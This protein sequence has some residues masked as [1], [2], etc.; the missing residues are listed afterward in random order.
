[1]IDFAGL[2]PL[3]VDDDKEVLE[4]MYRDSLV[5]PS[6]YRPG[7]FWQFYE[8][9]HYAAL[10]EHSLRDLGTIGSAIAGGFNAEEDYPTFFDW[11][12][13]I[14]YVN[15]D[16]P[17]F[18]SLVD[19]LNNIVKSAPDDPFLPYSLSISSLR[20]AAT[21]YCEYYGATRNARPLSDVNWPLLGRPGDLFNYKGKAV[22]YRALYYYTKYAFAAKHVNFDEIDVIVEL[23][24][25][26]GR[27]AAMIIDLHPH[28]TYLM[29]D[30]PTTLYF[31][32]QFL[33]A[34][35]PDRVA[36]YRHTRE[37]S[38]LSGLERGKIY[39]FGSWQFPLLREFQAAL[40]WNCQSLQEMEAEMVANYTAIVD[41]FAKS[42]LLVHSIAGVHTG[43]AG[44][45]SLKAP[46]ARVAD[47]GAKYL[48]SFDV[49][50]SVQAY[51]V[52]GDDLGSG[53]V[54]DVFLEKRA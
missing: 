38:S 13:G 6:I 34:A 51:D 27:Q 25:G 8:D 22:T 3:I 12:G 40:F 44:T 42:V 5:G 52:L 19:T 41:G 47:Y 43:S 2:K 39:H 37:M 1:M 54:Q 26:A 15:R 7:Q 49:L 36:G 24:G 31:C 17:G 23:G 18:R 35:F 30:I 53:G 50:E 20:R 14:A 45:T 9:K 21:R 29:F 16:N 32:H 11:G 28:I 33:S 48:P 4:L 10:R 46:G